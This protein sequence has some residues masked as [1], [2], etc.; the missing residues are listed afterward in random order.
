MLYTPGLLSLRSSITEGDG[1]FPRQQADT[2][3]IMFGEHSAESAV[4]CLHIRQ[5]GN[6]G[7]LV[8]RLGGSHHG[9]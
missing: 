3:D 2:P 4:C 5:G 7:G 1:E 9:I 6:S 8:F